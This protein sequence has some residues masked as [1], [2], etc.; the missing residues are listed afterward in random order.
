M[1]KLLAIVVIVTAMSLKLLFSLIAKINSKF[2]PQPQLPSNLGSG[3]TTKPAKLEI[4]VLRVLK[5]CG[6][7]V[8]EMFLIICEAFFD[9]KEE[10]QLEYIDEVLETIILY[11][12]GQMIIAANEAFDHEEAVKLFRLKAKTRLDQ[13]AVGRAS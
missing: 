10:L 11:C 1:L 2:F 3:N 7:D 4:D 9:H 8:L 6:P 13:R 12:G 5:R